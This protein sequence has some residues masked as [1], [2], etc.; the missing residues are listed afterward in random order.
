MSTFVIVIVL[1]LTPLSQ[2]WD[3][4]GR[5][6]SCPL[7]EGVVAPSEVTIAALVQFPGDIFVTTAELV[8]SLINGDDCLLP[9]FFFFLDCLFSTFTFF[10]VSNPKESKTHPNLFLFPFRNASKSCFWI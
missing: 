8:V 3:S 9:G 7:P 5:N 10:S 6:V 4:R 1:L 2:G